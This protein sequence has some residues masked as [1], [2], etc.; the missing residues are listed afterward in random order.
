MKC[1]VELG[2]DAMIYSYTPSFVKLSLG[3]QKLFWG[4]TQTAR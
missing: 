2:S 1:A 3:V 4:D